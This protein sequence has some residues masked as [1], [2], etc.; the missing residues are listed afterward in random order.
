M[1]NALLPDCVQ[2]W[3]TCASMATLKAE[4]PKLDWRCTG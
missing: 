2:F 1:H 3:L 4:S